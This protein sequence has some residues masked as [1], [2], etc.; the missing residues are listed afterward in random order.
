MNIIKIGAKV[1]KV[2]YGFTQSQ[3]L[4]KFFFMHCAIEFDR[5]SLLSKYSFT[6]ILSIHHHE[7][8]HT[9]RYTH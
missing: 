5:K 9:I 2:V 6:S 1:N 4:G 8:G 7:Y 3:R